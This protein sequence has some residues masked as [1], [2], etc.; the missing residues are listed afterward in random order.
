PPR[1]CVSRGRC[2]RAEHRCLQA[3]CLAPLLNRRRPEVSPLESLGEDHHAALRS[4]SD[5]GEQGTVATRV[6]APAAQAEQSPDRW[7]AELPGAERP[8][9]CPLAASCRPTQSL[10]A[11]PLPGSSGSDL[12]APRR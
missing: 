10:A 11:D 8:W 2:T 3:Y 1:P 4:R 7:H 5:S 9:V 12:P 6:A